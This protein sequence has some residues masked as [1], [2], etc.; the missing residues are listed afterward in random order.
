MASK[1]VKSIGPRETIVEVDASV[2]RNVLGFAGIADIRYYLNGVH[3]RAHDY[4]LL[5]AS[6]GHMAYCEEDRY[7]KAI[8][9]VTISISRTAKPFLKAGNRVVVEASLNQAGKAVEEG[10]LLRIVDRDEATVYIEPGKAV[11]ECKYPDIPALM[12]DFT[13]W[14]EG[15][16]GGFNTRLLS[17]VIALP[18]CVRFYHR[19]ADTNGVALFTFEPERTGRHGLG[20]VMPMSG[21]SLVEVLPAALRIAA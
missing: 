12:G 13:T 9:D 7:G 10:S 19:G 17:R 8:V 15:L 1:I 3:I 5:M 2:F 14:N 20:L 11:I 6:D 16:L 4:P 21:K 18:G